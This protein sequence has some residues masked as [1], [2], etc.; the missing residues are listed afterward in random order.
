MPIQEAIELIEKSEISRDLEKA[1]HNLKESLSQLSKESYEELG[2]HFY[3]LL[4]IMLKGQ[5]FFEK[6]IARYYYRKMSENFKKQEEKYKEELKNTEKREVVKMQLDVFYQMMERYFSSLESIYAKKDFLEARQRAFF[7]KMDYRK[8]MHK[9]R[10][11]YWK[12]LG[13]QFLSAA[14][15]YGTS[16]LRWG[17]T[18]L[19]FIAIFGGFYAL[20]NQ[21]GEQAIIAQNFY[22]YIYFSATT[23][24]T[25][26]FGDIVPLDTVGKITSNIEACT[27]FIMLG[28][29]I[30]LVQK[31]IL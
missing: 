2:V 17:L 16:F 27:G 4:R 28:V 14:S 10:E 30:G 13:Y 20:L 7:E 19:I 24:T 6:D 26:G 9:S 22:D 23:F 18:S 15:G 31:K 21:F 12:Y 29:F 1:S 25:L 8:R 5:I 11:E 3:Y